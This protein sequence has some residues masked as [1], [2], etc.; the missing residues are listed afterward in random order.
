MDSSS[1]SPSPQLYFHTLNAFQRTAALKTAI[2]LDLFTAVIEGNQS[3]GALAKRCGASE[4][5]IRILC[6]YLTIIGFLTKEDG[7]YRPTPDTQVFLDRRSPAYVGSTSTFMLSAPFSEGFTGLT[8]AVR[9]GGT[10]VGTDGTLDPEHPAWVEFARSMVPMMAGPAQ[11]IAEKVSDGGGQKLT[12]LDIAAG[13]GIFGVEI[14]KRHSQA[15]IVALDWANVLQVAREHADAA[16]VSDRYRTIAGNAF[17]AEMGS[18]YDVV[19]LTNFL[20]H[21]DPPTCESLLRKIHAAL[22][23]NGQVVTLEF[24]PNDDRISPAAAEFSIIMLATTP[25]GDAYTIAELERMF[26]NS[27]FARNELHPLPMSTESVIIS[28]K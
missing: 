12:V 17:D 3:T 18:G 27:G 6:D 13:H 4:R 2:D 15:E 5:G 25:A 28:Y 21:F 14:A 23:A 22:K 16:G 1:D 8:E 10:V 7:T 9:K 24:V 26:S 20:H 19:L 11:W